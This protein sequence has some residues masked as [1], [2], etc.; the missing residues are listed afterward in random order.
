M[1]VSQEGSPVDNDLRIDTTTVEGQLAL[2]QLA[3]NGLP[4]SPDVV[5]GKPE[6]LK[7]KR[8]SADRI[9]R[10]LRKKLGIDPSLASINSNSDYSKALG[11]MVMR[12]IPHSRLPWRNQ[13][14]KG[15]NE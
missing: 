15:G 7:P 14:S 8:R 6:P 3:M 5:L 10:M 4:P 9:L 12:P 11:E 1:P 13:R 2:A